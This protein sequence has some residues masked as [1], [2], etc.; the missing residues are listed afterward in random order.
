MAKKLSLK[1][2]TKTPGNPNKHQSVPTPTPAPRCPP[3][4]KK[5]ASAKKEVTTPSKIP[6]YL[7]LHDEIVARVSLHRSR[8]RY[9]PERA[10]A[11]Q[12]AS[13]EGAAALSHAGAHQAA[14]DQLKVGAAQEMK[15]HGQTCALAA[16]Q[17]QQYYRV[18][19]QNTEVV[20]YREHLAEAY[21]KA[22][23]LALRYQQAVF[24]FRGQQLVH[25]VG[26]G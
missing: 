3:E 7:V 6:R 16:E 22:H 17:H 5:K 21:L 10:M 24:V 25:T 23:S 26:F 12:C 14:A 9:R 2:L 4:P 19:V 15:D 20:F 8:H 13:R 18:E 1:K 11:A